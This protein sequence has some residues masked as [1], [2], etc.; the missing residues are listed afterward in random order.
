ML[1]DHGP[2]RRQVVGSLQRQRLHAGQRPLGQ[3]DQGAGRR[4]LQHGGHAEVRHRR[5]AQV[6]P[7]GAADLP[8]QPGQDLTSVVDDPTV[9]VG[10]Q[11]QPRVAR[12]DRSRVARE[13]ADGRCHVGRVERAGDLQRTHPR[14]LGRV[15]GERGQLLECPRD[16]D[17]ARTVLVG[18]RQAVLGG[19][20]HH[21]VGV[22]AED[23]A[24]AGRSD[25]RGRRH[26]AAALADQHHGL[27][28]REHAGTDRG[29]DLPDGVTGSCADPGE[30]SRRV[31]EQGQQ[32]DQARAD[33]ERLGHGRVADRLRVGGGAVGD[34]VHAGHGR[35]PLE[36]LADAIHL[37]PG[38]EESGGLRALAGRD[39]DEHSR[40]LPCS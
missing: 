16:D 18:R 37:Q 34:E 26:A 19:L 39:D 15:S 9:G 3:A 20:G 25:G 29:R 4:D 5:H 38:T 23:S 11:R 17:L 13:S 2:G 35:Q 36:S 12:G 8:D 21:G 6:P 28:G 7:H 40:S 24:H 27:L 14:P 31:G 30:A 10:D 32:A 1:L 22:A 33:D